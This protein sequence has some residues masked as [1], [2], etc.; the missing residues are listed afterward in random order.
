M[1]YQVETE[2]FSGPF[3][4][5]LQLVEKEKLD[6]TEISLS[7]VTDEFIKYLG[8]FERVQPRELA[9]FLE[10]AAKLILL[11]S[12]L[13]IPGAVS[14]DEDSQDLVN[15]L[16]IYRQYALAAKRVNEIVVN[17]DYAFARDKIPLQ[18]VPEFSLDIKIT[19]KVLEKNF[20]NIVSIILDQVKLS[21]RI[22]KRRIISLKEKVNELLILIKSR[23]KVIFNQVIKQKNKAEQ[24]VMFL[25]VLELMKEKEIN[26]SQNGLFEEIV[27]SKNKPGGRKE[28]I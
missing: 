1:S 7:K 2:Q 5:L 13:L 27:I 10:V 16:K 22:I 6:I 18:I 20:R 4:L 23:R 28:K 11:K 24:A 9:D 3:D 14:D 12:R 26:V 17:P 19:L 15:Q 8:N 21:Q 25:A